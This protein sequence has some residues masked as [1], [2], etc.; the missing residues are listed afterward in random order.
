MRNSQNITEQFLREAK[1]H[2]KKTSIYILSIYGISQNPDSKDY[3]MVLEY[4]EGG[5]LSKWINKNYDKFNWSYKLLSL[6]NIVRGL[7]EIHQK[8]MVHRDFHTGNIL[9][10]NEYWPCIADMGLCGKVDD[11]YDIDEKDEKKVFGVLP[12]VAPEVV[13]KVGKYTQASDIYSLGM[14]MYF[15]ATGKQP[16]YNRAH[17]Q[18]LAISICGGVR[19][20]ISEPEAPKCYIDL[21]KRCWD[22]NPDHRPN[23]DEIFE[24][25]KLLNDSKQ[26]QE[27]R[28]QLEEAEEYR[29]ANPLSIEV[30]QSNTHPQAIYT[31]RL[32]NSITKDFPMYD[33]INNITAEYIDFTAE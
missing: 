28:N 32:L 10:K 19:P 12:Y 2:S 30:I 4:V 26:P 17:D 33:N 14:L 13:L 20:E 7:K 23:I 22:A 21:M 5:D 24:T 9:I 1:V 25:M 11:N 16:F 29:K 3:I 27:I 15:I 6:W 31:S 18:Y 8:N